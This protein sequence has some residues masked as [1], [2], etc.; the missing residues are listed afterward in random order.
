MNQTKE[1]IRKD[2]IQQKDKIID[3]IRKLLKLGESPNEHE[4]QSAIM[5]AQKLAL[6]NGI[7]ISEIKQESNDAVVDQYIDPLTRV[8][9]FKRRISALLA[10]NFRVV[11]IRDKVFSWEDVKYK[12]IMLVVGL[13]EDVAIF[14]Q[15]FAYTVESYSIYLN[16]FLKKY[17]KTYPRRKIKQNLKNDYMIGFLSGLIYRFRQ[18]IQEHGLI[19]VTPQVVKNRIDEMK[20]HESK[21][22]KLSHKKDKIAMGMGYHDAK[23]LTPHKNI[24]AS[25]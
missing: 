6:K 9:L 14:K 23:S 21:S 5:K 24:K 15:V 20:C 7:E 16:A 22:R 17:K 2:S 25:T 10:T 8:P 4:A 3:K 1:K 13:P 18:N 12:E 19:V 11:V